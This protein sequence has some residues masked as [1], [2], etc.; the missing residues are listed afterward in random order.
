M[1][2]FITPPLLITDYYDSLISQ[3]DIYTEERTKEINEKGLAKIKTN[4]IYV[5]PS[6]DTTPTNKFESCEE[7]NN[8]YEN[9]MFTIYLTD[10]SD[11]SDTE[12]ENISQVEEY[13]IIS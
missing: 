9:Q 7:Y 1:S 2:D 13:M 12:I 10:K 6:S 3:L 8:P 5:K 11:K 4:Q